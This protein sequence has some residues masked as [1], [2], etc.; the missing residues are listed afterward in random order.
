MPEHLGVA[1]VVVIVLDDGEMAGSGTHD[2]LLK[3]CEVYRE[4]YYAQF[5]DEKE[6]V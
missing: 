2:E 4:I 1:Q 6:V 5:P 3:D